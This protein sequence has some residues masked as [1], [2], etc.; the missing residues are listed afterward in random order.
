MLGRL[1]V[2]GDTIVE[3]MIAISIIGVVIVGASAS[4]NRSSNYISGSHN[5]QQAIQVLQNQMELIKASNTEGIITASAFCASTNCNLATPDKFCVYISSGPDF[6]YVIFNASN[7]ESSA[8]DCYFNY[9]GSLFSLTSGY[10]VATLTMKDLSS[11]KYQLNGTITWTDSTNT[12]HNTNL[13]YE[14][15][16]N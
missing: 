5:R 1:G 3:V 16:S 2:K 10:Y 8:N 9:D 7:P 11:S 12:A 6:Q 14:L 15:T 13:S 4:V